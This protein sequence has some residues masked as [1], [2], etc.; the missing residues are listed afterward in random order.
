[1]IILHFPFTST[2][3]HQLPRH[4]T[5]KYPSEGWQ[6]EQSLFLCWLK[7]VWFLWRWNP[8]AMT[9]LEPRRLQQTHGGKYDKRFWFLEYLNL[10]TNNLLS[11]SRWNQDYNKIIEN[12]QSGNRFLKEKSL[13]FNK[14]TVRSTRI[15]D[16][17]F[18]SSTEIWP[19]SEKTT[20]VGDERADTAKGR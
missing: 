2:K 15:R 14:F 6:N 1:M 9:A 10:D 17:T 12:S 3:R 4:I 13:G 18:D 5:F 8:W 16:W 19:S 7:N 11:K 20:E